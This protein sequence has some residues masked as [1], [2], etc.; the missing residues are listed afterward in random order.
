LPSRWDVG[1]DRDRLARVGVVEMGRRARGDDEMR[2]EADEDETLRRPPGGAARRRRA[3]AGR[4]KWLVD[5][6][7][8]D[9]VDAQRS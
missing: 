9:E 8:D 6:T 3:S 7:G 5:Q 4:V 1:L 2:V